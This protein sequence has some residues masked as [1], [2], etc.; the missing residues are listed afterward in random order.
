L[1]LIVAIVGYGFG[2]LITGQTNRSHGLF[3]AKPTE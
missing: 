1:H 3:I 2:P